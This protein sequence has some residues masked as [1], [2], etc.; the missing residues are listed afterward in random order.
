MRP[1]AKHV[2]ASVAAV[3]AR[4][5]G[6]P[7]PV[8]HLIAQPPGRPVAPHVQACL[9]VRRG[10]S[11]FSLLGR[12]IPSGYG[13]SRSGLPVGCQPKSAK[14]PG[15]PVRPSVSPRS[16]APPP[17]PPPA[18]PA[19]NGGTRSPRTIQRA[20]SFE[21][22]FKQTGSSFQQALLALFHL[23]QED[24]TPEEVQKYGIDRLIVPLF[25]KLL[26]LQG[27]DLVFDAK[28]P[29]DKVLRKAGLQRRGGCRYG[30]V[31]QTQRLRLVS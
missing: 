22:K 15:L 11:R 5:S 10:L 4:V 14:A 3:Q 26:G 9:A 28:T 30:I 24:L 20:V 31:C 18:R 23:D 17:V 21:G 6:K 12:S 19:S 16:Q 1:L 25:P 13:T 27:T 7:G 8:P 29:W 2:Q